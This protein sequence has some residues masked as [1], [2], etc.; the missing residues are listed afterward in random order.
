MMQFFGTIVTKE[1]PVNLELDE[2]DI[3]HLTK[4]CKITII[5]LY[6]FFKKKNY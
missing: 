4:V 1:E 2:G 6:I 5:Q 3:F